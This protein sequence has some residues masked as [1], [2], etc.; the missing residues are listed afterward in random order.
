MQG[1]TLAREEDHRSFMDQENR[2]HNEPGPRPA[3]RS[4]VELS[5]YI[6]KIINILT[7]Y[8][9]PIIHTVKNYSVKTHQIPTKLVV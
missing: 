3:D 2:Q 1:K 6:T 7:S 9:S 5:S 8:H 4:C